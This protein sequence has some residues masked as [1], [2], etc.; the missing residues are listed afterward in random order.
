M[1]NHA[2][3]IGGMAIALFVFIGR[4]ARLILSAN[5]EE[6]ENSPPENLHGDTDRRQPSQ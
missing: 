3:K 4:L 6:I 2:K 5:S 1:L